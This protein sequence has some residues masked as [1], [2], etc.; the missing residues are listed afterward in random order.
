MPI[1]SSEPAF[2]FSNTLPNVVTVIFFKLHLKSLPSLGVAVLYL[3]IGYLGRNNE[4][5]VV[6]FKKINCF[7]LGKVMVKFL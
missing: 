3:N 6:L 5:G 4:E 2:S 1:Q 7:I